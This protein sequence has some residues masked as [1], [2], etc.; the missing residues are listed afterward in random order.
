MEI[1][2]R[3]ERSWNTTRSP[4][5]KNRANVTP[6]MQASGSPDA[7]H[8]I[9]ALLDSDA[10]V[11]ANEDGRSPLH[12][13]F[14]D[15]EAIKLLVAAGA[16]VNEVYQGL[17]PLM[18][19]T[20]RFFI[21]KVDPSQRRRHRPRVDVVQTLVELGADPHAR[22]ENDLRSDLPSKGKSILELAE[23]L[24]VHPKLLEALNPQRIEQ[25]SEPEQDTD[26]FVDLEESTEPNVQDIDPDDDNK[27]DFGDDDSSSAKQDTEQGTEPTEQDTE[28]KLNS[29]GKITEIR[30][31]K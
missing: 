18:K 9:Q 19:H 6:I 2:N 15:P 22:Y 21:L 11:V 7:S 25:D 24:D 5:V 28:P 8:I 20:E 31:K 4:N 17:T 1:G 10:S 27:G 13:V 12:Y 30:K 29:G 14:E 3:L 16:N 23:E 26:F